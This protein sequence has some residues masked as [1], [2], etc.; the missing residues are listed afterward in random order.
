MF[1]L[2]YHE[3]EKN[4]STIIFHRTSTLPDGQAH[5]A[6]VELGLS[7]AIFGSLAAL[8]LMVLPPGL[9]G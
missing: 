3:K 4:M 2:P 9:V 8:L 7:V 1:P 5:R 6:Q